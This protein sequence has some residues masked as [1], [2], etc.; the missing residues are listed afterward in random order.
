MSSPNTKGTVSKKRKREHEPKQ[1][2]T[3]E[4]TA[5]ILLAKRRET[6]DIVAASE[7]TK[8]DGPF[9][10]TDCKAELILKKCTTKL[11]HFSHKH[12]GTCTSQ[13]SVRRSGGGGESNVHKLAKLKVQ[14]NSSLAVVDVC[15]FCMC[16]LKSHSDWLPQV[17]SKKPEYPHPTPHGTYIFDLACFKHGSSNIFGVIEICHKNPVHATKRKQIMYVRSPG[18]DYLYLPHNVAWETLERNL[19]Q[20]SLSSKQ[21][22]S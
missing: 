11:C 16:V 14:Q 3:R 17:T 13:S 12:V 19:E 15:R 7:A 8:A 2:N 6:G 20:N 5:T 18:E 4:E 1:T 21:T 9:E 22:T 10:C